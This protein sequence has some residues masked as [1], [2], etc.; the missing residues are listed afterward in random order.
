MHPQAFH[1]SDA[2]QP[3]MQYSYTPTLKSGDTCIQGDTFRELLL[4]AM[5]RIKG[6]CKRHWHQDG[7]ISGLKDMQEKRPEGEATVSLAWLPAP[8]AGETDL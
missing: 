2:R 4:P 1:A 8:I 3:L 7:T 6:G 5:G